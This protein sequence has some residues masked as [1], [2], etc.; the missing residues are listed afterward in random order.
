MSELKKTIKISVK[1]LHLKR[2]GCKFKTSQNEKTTKEKVEDQAKMY[3]TLRQI[4]STKEFVDQYNDGLDNP[5][6]N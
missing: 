2:K 6:E 5:L 3:E 4:M 1:N